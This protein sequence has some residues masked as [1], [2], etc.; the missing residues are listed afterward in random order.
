[1]PRPLHMAKTEIHSRRRKPKS[2]VS[3][4]PAAAEVKA[5][6][7]SLYGGHS[8]ASS[9]SESST[10]K[11]GDGQGYSSPRDLSPGNLAAS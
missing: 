10:H 8:A 11:G 3:P 1:M 6:D 9:S 2:T 4:G 7:F 5:V